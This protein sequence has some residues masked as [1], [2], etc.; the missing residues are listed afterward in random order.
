MPCP[1]RPARPMRQ[2]AR[3]HESD[4]AFSCTL[5]FTRKPVDQLLPF[6]TGASRKADRRPSTGPPSSASSSHV[7]ETLDRVDQPAEWSARTGVSADRRRK[8]CQ[9]ARVSVSSLAT[10]CLGHVSRG[11]LLRPATACKLRGRRVKKPQ[12]QRRWPTLEPDEVRWPQAE[13]PA[14]GGQSLPRKIHHDHAAEFEVPDDVAETLVDGDRFLAEQSDVAVN[15]GHPEVG[16]DGEGPFALRRRPRRAGAVSTSA[17]MAVAVN[18]MP[19][20]NDA[21]RPRPSET[22][23]S[24]FSPSSC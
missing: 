2:D 23:M 17:A 1:L 4:S 21:D 5:P 7:A 3:A 12:N 19:P 20:G 18:A 24:R 9:L 14:A 6:G 11:P 10:R 8:S 16:G 15:A 13:A 22:F